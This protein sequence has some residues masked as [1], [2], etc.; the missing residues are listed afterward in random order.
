MALGAVLPSRPAGVWIDN[1]D[2]IRHTFTIEELDVDLEIPA[3]KAKRVEFD[4]VAGTYTYICTVPGHENM[5]G[6]LVVEG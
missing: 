3:L 4:A 1:K 6:T 5:T 2:G